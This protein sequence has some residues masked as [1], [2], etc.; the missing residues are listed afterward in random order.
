MSE[1]Y[2]VT[3]LKNPCNKGRFLTCDI[4]KYDLAAVEQIAD[5]V[6]CHKDLLKKLV[7]GICKRVTDMALGDGAVPGLEHSIYKE[8]CSV[9]VKTGRIYV[10]LGEIQISV[11]HRRE[12]LEGDE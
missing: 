8:F 10:D 6:K 9:L 2:T 11:R 3:N 12:E 1:V 4:S 7:D 5:Q